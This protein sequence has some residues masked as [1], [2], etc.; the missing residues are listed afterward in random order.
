MLLE[1]R[2]NSQLTPLAVHNNCEWN[3]LQESQLHQ[4][5]SASN[6]VV[7]ATLNLPWRFTADLSV[8]ENT[9]ERKLS[10]LPQNS[11]FKGLDSLRSSSLHI[12]SNARDERDGFS[13][14]KIGFVKS[15]RCDSTIRHTWSQTRIGTQ[16]EN[17]GHKWLH[18]WIQNDEF[19]H[20]W[21]STNMLPLETFPAGKWSM[22]HLDF[23]PGV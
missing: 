17:S 16:I 3:S 19:W 13:E 9:Y 1:D 18:E 22:F 10:T 14:T 20:L 7:L 23:E 8:M 11:V 12:L 5:S 4:D 6:S 21:L 2:E 15:S